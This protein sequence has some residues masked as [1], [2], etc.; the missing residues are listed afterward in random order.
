MEP[1]N[2][3]LIKSIDVKFPILPKYPLL[4]LV[5]EHIC[6]PAITISQL[7]LIILLYKKHKAP[8]NM[9][10]SQSKK[11]TQQPL[12]LSSPFFLAAVT[13]WFS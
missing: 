12:E 8:P 6:Q 9:V 1:S 4:Y 10:S 5:P 3:P 11:K 7:C 2:K 13:P